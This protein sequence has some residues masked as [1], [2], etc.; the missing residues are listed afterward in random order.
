MH[1]EA[2]WCKRWTCKCCPGRQNKYKLL[3]ICITEN[4]DVHL[5]FCNTKRKD[6]T[7][8]NQALWLMVMYMWCLLVYKNT[9]QHMGCLKITALLG[10]MLSD[11][12]NAHYVNNRKV[13]V[14]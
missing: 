12:S 13:E 2:F 10:T 11:L 3:K 14:V 1:Q 7:V 8:E 4:P 6:C 9:K 5:W